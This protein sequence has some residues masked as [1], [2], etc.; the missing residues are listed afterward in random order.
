M[1]G[2]VTVLG[3]LLL[4][5]I[6]LMAAAG[7]IL[8]FN[9]MA[10]NLG[11]L[12]MPS[13]TAMLVVATVFMIVGSVSVVLGY[14]AR[15]GALLL[16]LFLLPATYYGHAFWKME[17]TEQQDHLIHFMKNLSMMGAMLFIIVNGAGPGSID[18]SS[19]T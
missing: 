13:P 1:S 10:A 14:K 15:I 8:R 16:F 6:F 17:G 4:C 5:A 3:R 11:R 19:K 9:D 7:N 18:G 12:G 2:I